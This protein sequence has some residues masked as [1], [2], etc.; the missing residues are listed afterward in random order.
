[1]MI[2]AI[3]CVGLLGVLVFGLGLA[4]S[5]TRTRTETLYG[6]GD[7]PTSPLYK[8]NRAH[9]NAIEYSPMLAI[10]MVLI[11]THQPA[12]WI[13]WVIILATAFRYIHAVGLITGGTMNAFNV[14]RFIGALGTYVTG[15]I[16]ALY[17]I[18]GW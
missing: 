16:L 3:V 8:M 14:L 12:G 5:L 17:V 18:F 1:M 13:A 15:L 9:G 10:L 7:D 6:V 4:V 11:G 2:S